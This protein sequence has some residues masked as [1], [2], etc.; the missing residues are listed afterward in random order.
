MKDKYF[1]PQSRASELV[2]QGRAEGGGSTDSGIPFPELTVNLIIEDL[3]YVSEI[4]CAVYTKD[5]NRFERFYKDYG[6]TVAPRELVIEGGVVPISIPYQIYNG[7]V[8]GIDLGRVNVNGGNDTIYYETYASNPVNL[9]DVD[10]SGRFFEIVDLTKPA[11][12][13]VTAKLVEG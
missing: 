1:I 10:G 4:S 11:S 7:L 2:G 5:G 3:E 8:Y 6:S 9:N 13:T 12:I